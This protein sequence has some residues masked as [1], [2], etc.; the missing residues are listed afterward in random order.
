MIIIIRGTRSYEIISAR[1]EM[2]Y[3]VMKY[4]FVLIKAK[5]DHKNIIEYNI[6][7]YIFSSIFFQIS[8]TLNKYVEI[9]KKKNYEIYK[10]IY[11]IIK[12]IQI[13]YMK[14]LHNICNSQK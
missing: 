7:L 3:K 8:I 6:I 2:Q 13:H 9:R 11:M 10:I 14:Q 5:I 4:A 12:I 1:I